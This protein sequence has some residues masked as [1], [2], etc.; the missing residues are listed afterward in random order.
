MHY[1]GCV[2]RNK[3]LYQKLY[4]ISIINESKA[5]RGRSERINSSKTIDNRIFIQYSHAHAEAC[6]SAVLNAGALFEFDWLDV[7]P[8]TGAY[9]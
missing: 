7:C 8:V 1:P 5:P 9:M 6:C 2:G 3:C 4:R